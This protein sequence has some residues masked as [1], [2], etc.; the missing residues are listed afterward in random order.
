MTILIKTINILTLIILILFVLMIGSSS[1]TG[2]INDVAKSGVNI[3]QNLPIVF[4]DSSMVIFL[5][6]ISILLITTFINSYKKHKNVQKAF[7]NVFEIE[8][9]LSAISLVFS[10]SQLSFIMYVAMNAIME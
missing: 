3:I 10:I 8:N 7:K 2:A 6:C 5:C 9:K 4:K 1:T